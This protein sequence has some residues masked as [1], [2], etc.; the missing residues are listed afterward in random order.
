M[1]GRGAVGADRPGT[2]RQ[3]RNT[4]DTH[5]TQIARQWPLRGM[6]SAYVRCGWYVWNEGE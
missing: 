5:N 3:S 2:G 4:H 1:I 6:L